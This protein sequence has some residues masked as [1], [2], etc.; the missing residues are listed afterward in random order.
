[1]DKIE[2][3]KKHLDKLEKDMTSYLWEMKFT[4]KKK[5]ISV[6]IPAYNEERNIILMSHLISPIL[7]SLKDKKTWFE[8]QKYEYDHEIIFINDGSKDDSWNNIVESSRNNKNIRWINFSRNFW[9][10]VALSAGLEYSNWDIVITLDA[11]LQHPIEK[12]P[13]FISLWEKWYD[14][15]YNI[16]PKIKWAKFTKRIFSKIFYFFYNN[17][18]NFKFE[19]WIT[20]YRLLDKKVVKAFLSFHEKNRIYRW[21]I[22]YLWFKKTHLVFDANERMDWEAWYTF[23]KLLQLS[24]DALTSFSVKPLKIILTSWIIVILFSFILFF[25]VILNNFWIDIIKNN[26]ENFMLITNIFLFWIVMCFMGLMWL[27]IWNIH[28]EVKRR[29]LYIVN[30]Q[31]NFWNDEKKNKE[32]EIKQIIKDSLSEF[33]KDNK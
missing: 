9:K 14:I 23:W 7:E 2:N 11:D 4:E 5:L 8:W 13:E 3:I 12:I 24:I 22:D 29:P 26:I 17:L 33:L 28:E 27:Y 21:I 16:R 20:D 1:M 19:P 15:V 25:I 10:E 31:E 32:I 18:S 6:V 30:E